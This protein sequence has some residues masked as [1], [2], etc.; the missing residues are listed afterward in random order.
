[1][2]EQRTLDLIHAEL[3]GELHVGDLA[4][5]QLRL[6]S[7]P[8]A[9]A[10][11][12]HL[13]AIAGA[14]GR[15]PPVAPPAGLQEQILQ[16]TRPAAKVLPFRNRRTQFVRYTMALAAGVALAAVGIQFSGNSGYSLEADQLVGT[17]GGQASAPGQAVSE[18]ALQAADL[19]GSVGLTPDAGRWQLVFELASRQ[20]VTVTAAYAEAAFRLN[21]YSGGD[22]AAAAISATP[23]HIEF[24]NQ[25]EQRLVLFLE[26]GAGGP[27]RISFEGQGK[28]LQEAVLDVPGQAPE[29]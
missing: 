12:D 23:G 16:A 13:G 24:V 27:V 25:G 5:L 19:K 21:G 7:D 20:P 11:R 15:M 9:R 6:E 22:P 4:E 3:D 10:M 26:P 29:K 28:L 2:I 14:L 17:I 18:V 1:M 8:E